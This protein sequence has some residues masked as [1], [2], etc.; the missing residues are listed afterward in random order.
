[1]ITHEFG[2]AHF[3]TEVSNRQIA[4]TNRAVHSKGNHQLLVDR[5]RIENIQTDRDLADDI[6]ISVAELNQGRVY[7]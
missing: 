2:R 4:S 6:G 3:V 5:R 1:M 7:Q